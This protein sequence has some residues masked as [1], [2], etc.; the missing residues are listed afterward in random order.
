MVVSIEGVQFSRILLSIHLKSGLIRE[1]D[2]GGSD[3][4][5]EWPIV[6]DTF[7][8]SGQLWEIPLVGV[9]LGGSDLWW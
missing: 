8:G 9:A 5:W 2:F 1:A 4:W 3:L 7:G 6:G